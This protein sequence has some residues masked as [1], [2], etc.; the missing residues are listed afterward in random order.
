MCIC[1]SRL[2]NNLSWAIRNCGLMLLNALLSRLSGGNNSHLAS[3][4][5]GRSHL[6]KHVYDKNP[7]LPDL[8]LRLLGQNVVHPIPNGNPNTPLSATLR[9]FQVL[10]P[11]MEII[12]QFGIPPDHEAVVVKIL[13][14]QLSSPIWA[15]REKTAEVLSL[16]TD[17]QAVI[18][19]IQNTSPHGWRQNE[20]HGQLLCLKSMVLRTNNAETSK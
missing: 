12:K 5:S 4:N 2:T 7:N 20:L 8:I 14:K 10:F 18:R 16:L 3:R 17:E 9:S 11:A 1:L 13:K 6:S 19:D 15:L